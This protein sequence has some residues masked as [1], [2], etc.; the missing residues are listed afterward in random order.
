MEKQVIELPREVVIGDDVLEEVAESCKRIGLKGPV[1]VLSGTKTKDIAG[2]KVL[3]IL[4]KAGFKSEFAIADSIKKEDVDKIIEE[5]KKYNFIVGVGGG[6]VIDVAKYSAFKLSIPFVSV[7]TAPSH[8][9]IASSR[10][11]LSYNGIKYSYDAR[12]PRA[13]IAD[14]KIV[15]RAPFRLI[16][17]GCAD[18]IAKITAV[19]DWRL[20]FDEK[21]EEY[22]EYAASLALLGAQTVLSST[23][24]IKGREKR[25]IKNLLQSLISSSIAMCIAGSSRPASGSEHLISHAL[26]TLCPDKRSLHGEQCGVGCII[27]SYLHGMEWQKIRDALKNLGCPVNAKELGISDAYII[28]AISTARLIRANRYTI[29]DKVNM[30]KKK[31]EEVAKITGVI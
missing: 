6:T 16:A 9:G 13:I 23:D 5:S 17:S 21:G 15:S 18:M 19:A 28:K 2:L 11:T 24:L 4:K 8:D 20:A 29:L 7:P 30:D 14:L 26:D 31:A 12:A 25:G 27:A 22:S 1:L 3:D 10:A